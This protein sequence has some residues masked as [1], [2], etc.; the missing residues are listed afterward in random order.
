M[1]SA[2]VLAHSKAANSG[3][4]AY[5]LRIVMPRICLSEFN[6]HRIISKNTS[7]SRA[8]PIMKMIKHAVQNMFYPV[9]WGSNRAGMQATE[10]LKG[11]RLWLAKKAWRLIGLGAA[12]SALILNYIGLH[13]QTA[14]RVIENFTYVTVIFTT[15]DL[16]NFLSLRDHK[17]AMPEI[18]EIASRIRMAVATSIP[19]ILAPGKWHL[20]LVTATEKLIFS[21]EKLRLLSAARCASTSYQTVDGKDIDYDT[22]MKIANKLMN[23]TPIHASPFEHQLTPDNLVEIDYRITN[24]KKKYKTIKVWV[25]PLKHGNTVGFIQH[26]KLI[27]GESAV[28]SAVKQGFLQPLS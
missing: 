11:I 22:A 23:S 19:E 3:I 28:N 26:R 25:D 16:N 4:E 6:T 5:T 21:I 13:K 15:T 10:E 18:R 2:E 20:P 1:Y 8:I 17:D 24:S 7:S 12:T 27:E 14:N 9:Y